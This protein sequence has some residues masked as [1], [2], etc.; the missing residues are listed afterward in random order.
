VLVQC[1]MCTAVAWS[2]PQKPYFRRR[3]ALKCR[4]SYYKIILQNVLSIYSF[5][6][7]LHIPHQIYLDIETE[8]GEEI[9]GGG[10]CYWAV[11]QEAGHGEGVLYIVQNL[12]HRVKALL[13]ERAALMKS[14]VANWPKIRPQNSIGAD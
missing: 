7:T 14:I 6:L 4:K 2:H 9:L 10:L 13:P 12:L 3:R 8:L 11:G 1:A 5:C